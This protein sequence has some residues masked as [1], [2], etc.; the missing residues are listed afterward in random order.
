MSHPRSE[1]RHIATVKALEDKENE[2]GTPLHLFRC[3]QH[4]GGVIPFRLPYAI[5][6]QVVETVPCRSYQVYRCQGGGSDL[7]DNP[8]RG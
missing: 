1:N 7:R 2:Y 5:C 6:V 8:R 3:A 4:A